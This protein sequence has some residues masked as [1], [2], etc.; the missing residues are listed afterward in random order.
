[1]AILSD[2]KSPRIVG[3]FKAPG[4]PREAVL[5]LPV[6]LYHVAASG[7]IL[8][9]WGYGTVVDATTWA[10]KLVLAPGERAVVTERDAND[11]IWQRYERTG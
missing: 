5:P 4:V 3:T 1:M 9:R 6:S 10:D 7:A 2:G 8:H 11:V